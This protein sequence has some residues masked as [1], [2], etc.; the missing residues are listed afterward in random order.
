[1][2]AGTLNEQYQQGGLMVYEDDDNYVKFN[3]VL[4]N[5]AGATRYRASSCAPRSAGRCSSPSRTS[6]SPPRTP[7]RSTCG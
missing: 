5:V 2:D 1:M 7:R 3:L 4:D 6:R